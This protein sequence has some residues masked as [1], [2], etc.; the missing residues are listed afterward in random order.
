M[1]G[2]AIRH[3]F[4]KG[5]SKDHPSQIW[6]NLILWFQKRRF[7]C[8]SLRRMPSDG[9]FHMAF[10]QV[11]LKRLHRSKYEMTAAYRQGNLNTCI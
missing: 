10:G 9:N 11:S 3:N 6:F 1:E 2:G 5:P 8:G 7:K 4:E